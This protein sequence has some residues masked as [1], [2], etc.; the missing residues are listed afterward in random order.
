MPATYDGRRDLIDL[1]LVEAADAVRAGET[2]AVA[3]T[4][5]SL[6]A[7]DARQ[8]E[9]N[10]AIR[11][12]AQDA[13][14]AAEGLDKLRNAGRLLG[15]LHGVPLAHKDMYYQAGKPSTGGSKIRKAFVPSYSSTALERL[16][17]AGAITVGA[18]NM[19]EF[20][21]NPTGHNAHFG[22]CRNPWNLAH[23]PGGSSSGSGAAVAA[24]L[25][26]GAL[27]SDTGGSIRLPAA[28][29]GVTAPCRCRFRQTMLDHWPERRE[30]APVSCTRFLATIRAIRLPRMSPCPTTRPR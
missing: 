7:F 15:P 19:A 13:L 22:H 5:A 3:L 27:G 17:A 18:L 23:C 10:A 12:D 24:R 2:T 6:A 20:A 29:C 30:I 14:E 9:L 28:M 1:S 8:S 21:Q 4:T 26:F 25:T 16:E 11:I